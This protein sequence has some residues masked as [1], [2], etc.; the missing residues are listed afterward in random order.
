CAHNDIVSGRLAFAAA[1]FPLYRSAGPRVVYFEGLRRFFHVLDGESHRPALSLRP[2]DAAWLESVSA[3]FSR[4]GH[5]WCGRSS[6]H[7]LGR[8]HGAL[9]IACTGKPS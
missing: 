2:A 5:R 7:G 6:A 9:I 4:H 1:V 8:G 3:G